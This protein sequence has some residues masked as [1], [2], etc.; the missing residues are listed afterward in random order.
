MS[1]KLFISNHP[2]DGAEAAACFKLC[3]LPVR[4]KPGECI[5][6][7]PPVCLIVAGEAAAVRGHQSHNAPRWKEAAQSQDSGHRC[8]D[9]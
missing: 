8:K 7:P 5:Y 1:E 3:L 4:L 6:L 2:P 9:L